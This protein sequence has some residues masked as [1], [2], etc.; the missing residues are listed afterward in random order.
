V[1]HTLALEVVD[2]ARSEAAG[3]EL[4]RPTARAT[5]SLSSGLVGF[6]F[7]GFV[8]RMLAVRVNRVAVRLERQA[9]WFRGATVKVQELPR[10]KLLD[11]VDDLRAILDDMERDLLAIRGRTLKL[12]T[13][14]RSAG[15]GRGEVGRAMSQV[16]KAAS[17]LYEEV[18]AFKG[19][20]QA[21]D[22]DVCNLNTASMVST[23]TDQLEAVLHDLTSAERAE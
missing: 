8:G 22:A 13:R 1:S 7:A 2:L 11:P 19:A 6:I 3:F 16:A 18:R 9:V 10:T 21:Y 17:E 20:V 5:L 15:L 14:R 12:L 4:H 23:S